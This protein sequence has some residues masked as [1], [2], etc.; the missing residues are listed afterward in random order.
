M[1]SACDGRGGNDDVGPGDQ[2]QEAISPPDISTGDRF[3]T[4]NIGA[5]CNPAQGGLG[6]TGE[7]TC[8]DVS[9]AACDLQSGVGCGICALGG[10]TLENITTPVKEDTCPKGSACTRVPV[11]ERELKTFCL[12][13]CSPSMTTNP[14][15]HKGVTCHPASIVFNDHT[16]V[17]LFPACKV[18]ADCGNKDPLN[19]DSLCLAA[20]GICLSR[21]STKGRVGDPCT[22]SK[23]CGP[24][25]YCLLEQKDASGKTLLQGGYCT[26][27]GCKYFDDQDPQT[28]YWQCP[29]ES[30]CFYMGSGQF[31]SFCLATNCDPNAPDVSDGCRDQAAAG[32]YDCIQLG[33]EKACWIT[34]K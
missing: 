34:V 29:S 31:V 20:S 19:P 18:D 24:Y 28:K 16:E 27:V 15:T 1:L 2:Q 8:L 12:P 17:C 4:A 33:A 5:P 11:A 30:T 23:D 32:Q 14:C 13:S 26:V 9:G 7:A 25:Q 3:S 21:G 10:C 22:K 6:C